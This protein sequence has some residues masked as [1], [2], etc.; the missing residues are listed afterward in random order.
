L[1]GAHDN[2]PSD[3]AAVE[4]DWGV[5]F[6]ADF[7]S[8]MNFGRMDDYFQIEPLPLRSSEPA[9]NLHELKSGAMDQFPDHPSYPVQLSDAPTTEFHDHYEPIGFAPIDFDIRSVFEQKQS[10]S[11]TCTSCRPITEL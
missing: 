9:R 8:S 4:G 2:R 10:N 11:P 5:E 6:E 1:A 3:S 7:D